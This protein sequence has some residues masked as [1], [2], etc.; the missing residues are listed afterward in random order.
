[1]DLFIISASFLAI[2]WFLFIG[3]LYFAIKNKEAGNVKKSKRWFNVSQAGEFIGD[4][5][6]YMVTFSIITIVLRAFEVIR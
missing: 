3:G 4:V 5:S 6:V 2:G 1:M